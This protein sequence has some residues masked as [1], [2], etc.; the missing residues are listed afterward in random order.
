MGII[1]KEGK[2]PRSKVRAKVK[3]PQGP[4]MQSEE[5]ATRGKSLGKHSKGARADM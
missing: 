3:K 1:R 5:N 4:P 2:L